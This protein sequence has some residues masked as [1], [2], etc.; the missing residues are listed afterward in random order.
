MIIF[1]ASGHAKVIIDILKSIKSKESIDYIIDNDRSI[2]NLLEFTV[3]HD[4]VSKMKNQ[5]VV[6]AI[7]NN[8]IRKKV[9]S[10]IENNFCDPLVHNSAVVSAYA[11][12][13]RGSVVMSNA[14]INSSVEIGDHCIVNSGAIVEH[15]SKIE[16]FVHI[17][18]STTITGNVSIGEGTHIGAGAIV[19][20]GVT[21]G[22]WVTV[23]AGA[24][25][26]SDLP[27]FSVVV[28]NPGKVIKYKKL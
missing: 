1:G 2:K 3:E 22:K 20:P 11:I 7:G 18:P 8:Q 17:S 21:I 9:A 13:G 4:L 28:G 27:D 23:G 16:D 19:I 6:I 12:L 14:V 10:K 26:I 24:V 5:N 25:I 15:D